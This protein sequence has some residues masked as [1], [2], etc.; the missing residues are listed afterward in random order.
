MTSFGVSWRNRAKGAAVLLAA[1]LCAGAAGAATEYAP[2]GR[3]SAEDTS[4]LGAYLA[5]RHAQQLH[6]YGA[7]ALYIGE[8]LKADPGNNDLVRRAFLLR[9]GGGDITQA[10]P[11]ATRIAD[12]DRR[13][14][15]ADLVLVLQA[16]KAGRYDEALT[17]AQ[18]LPKEGVERLAAPILSAWA[19]IGQN[20]PSAAMALVSNPKAPGSIPELTI[21]HAALIADRA[22]RID[23]AVKN[24]DKL[25]NAASRMTWRSVELAGNFFERH[26]RDAVARRL[27]DKLRAEP[28][29]GA[30]VDAA[31][32]R[33]DSGTIPKRLIV[34][35]QDG[36]AEAM[37]DLASI[38][39]ARDTFDLA[40]IHAH[41]ALYLKPDFPIAQLLLA[42]LEEQLGHNEKALALYR[43]IDRTS[44]LSWSARLREAA[45]LDQIGRTDE[46]VALLREM[47]GERPR[48]RQPAIELGD[49]LRSHD[50]FGEAVIAYDDALARIGKNGT[51]DWR[52]YYSRGIAL[53]RSHQWPRAEADF[54]QALALEP[55]QPLVL[56]YLGYSWI[57]QGS[58]LDEGLKMVE[59]AVALRPTDGYIVDSLGWAYFRLGDYGKAIEKLERAIEMVPEDPTINDHLGDAYW[60]GG[61]RLEARFQWN[62][63][64]QFKPD[65][66][67][68][69][70]IESKLEHGLGAPQ[71]ATQTKGG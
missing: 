3:T 47:A 39:N 56:N 21:F 37:F 66:G 53:E 25:T 68:I 10:L 50:R 8:A 4:P 20:K 41:L 31:M 51:R 36:A 12:L 48:D 29:N 61:R 11:L 23:D 32:A 43:A 60:R 24:Y 33:L 65:Q 69:Q 35:P 15:M 44:P 70:K 45:T 34:T 19:E 14:G 1:V 18:S 63:A 64:L 40:L 27:Y 71:T 55:E 67:E 17:R 54:R 16:F 30:V 7:A 42:E 9:L 5:A 13:S 49:I 38:L 28:E 22:D 26:Q 6:D 62:R 59:R 2:P 57:D 58:H 46:A 52:L